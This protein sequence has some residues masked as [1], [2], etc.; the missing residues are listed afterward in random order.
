MICSTDL[1]T[2]RHVHVSSEF[3]RRTAAS[4]GKHSFYCIACGIQHGTAKPA[5]RRLLIT[6]STLYRVYRFDKAPGWS[7]TSDHFDVEAIVGGTVNDGHEVFQH[8]YG[9]QPL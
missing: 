8:L 5:R 6:S 3:D 2:V 7:N 1:A 9:S 4:G